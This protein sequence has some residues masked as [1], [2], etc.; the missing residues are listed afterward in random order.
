MY[1]I[2][3]KKVYQEDTQREQDPTEEEWHEEVKQV[4]CGTFLVQFLGFMITIKHK[5]AWLRV[6]TSLGLFKLL[7]FKNMKYCNSDRFNSEHQ[8]GESQPEHEKQHWR[9]KKGFK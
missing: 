9:S 1:E 7:I 4:K 2:W 5:I 6:I 8:R 3:Q